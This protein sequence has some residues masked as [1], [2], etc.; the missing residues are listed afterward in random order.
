MVG[1]ALTSVKQRTRRQHACA[2]RN[3]TYTGLGCYKTLPAALNARFMR[4]NQHLMSR[5]GGSDGDAKSECGLPGTRVA[6]QHRQVTESKT[7]SQQAV[8]GRIARRDQI[9]RRQRQS[10]IAGKAL[11]D[12]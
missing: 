10:V 9:W 6:D 3:L 2:Y 11:Q 12:C 5:H 4:Q 7:P 1:P 8:E